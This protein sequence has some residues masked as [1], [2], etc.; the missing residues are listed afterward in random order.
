MKIDFDFFKTE[1]PESRK[2]DFY[3]DYLDGCVFIDFN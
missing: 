2:A 3:L 1:M